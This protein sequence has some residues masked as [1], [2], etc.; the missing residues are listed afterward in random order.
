MG[1]V[2]VPP[3]LFVCWF[4]ETIDLVCVSVVRMVG[5]SRIE[6]LL[7]PPGSFVSAERVA[8]H[9]DRS[10]WRLWRLLER[11]MPRISPPGFSGQAWTVLPVNCVLF[12]EDPY[13]VI[14]HP[15]RAGQITVDIQNSG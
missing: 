13:Y 15:D 3:L 10:T 5:W 6:Q 12:F 1:T 11:T 2:S 4:L 8:R 14:T 7:N 9:V